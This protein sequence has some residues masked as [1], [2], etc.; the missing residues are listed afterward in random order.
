MSVESLN[1]NTAR[2][3]NA[4]VNGGAIVSEVEPSGAAARAGI[5][6]GDIILSINDAAVTSVAQVT[7]ALDAIAVGRTARI[8]IFRD[9]Q[10][11][12]TFVRRQ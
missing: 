7:K 11:T 3:A 10:E 5:R 12:M 6:A 9:G 2:R 4:P 8:L 1:G